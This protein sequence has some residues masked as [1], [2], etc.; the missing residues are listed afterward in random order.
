[1]RHIIKMTS[2][3]SHLVAGN[4]E[5]CEIVTAGV[6]VVFEDLRVEADRFGLAPCFLFLLL[7]SKGFPSYSISK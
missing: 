5:M 7:P 2:S 1:M 6:P 3:I 4:F